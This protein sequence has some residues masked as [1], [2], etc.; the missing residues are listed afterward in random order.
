METDYDQSGPGRCPEGL[1]SQ[2][3]LPADA[4]CASGEC[5]GSRCCRGRRC[6][7]SLFAFSGRAFFARGYRLGSGALNQRLARRRIGRT[8]SRFRRGQ[9][10]AACQT[11]RRSRRHRR[12]EYPKDVASRARRPLRCCDTDGPVSADPIQ[13]SRSATKAETSLKRFRFE[14]WIGA[15]LKGAI[16]A[17][18]KGGNQWKNM[19]LLSAPLGTS[20]QL[21]RG[22]IRFHLRK[23]FIIRMLFAVRS[24]GNPTVIILTKAESNELGALFEKAWP[25]IQRAARL[26]AVARLA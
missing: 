8:G 14:Y 9:R 16:L 11:S 20:Y 13:L 12:L 24:I 15:A 25:A 7:R 21:S 18:H 17:A 6:L 5:G 10:S 2:A 1:G 22:V 26:T 4:H 23:S 19:D 3:A